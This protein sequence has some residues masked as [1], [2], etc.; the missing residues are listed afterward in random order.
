MIDPGVGTERKA[1]QAL[2]KN[3][4]VDLERYQRLA[5]Q[6]SIAGQQVDTQAALVRQYEATLQTDQAQI[7]AAQLKLT[8]S[9]VTA[10]VDGRV[11]LRQVDLGNY[12]QVGGTTGIVVITQMRPM[13]VVFALPQDEVSTVLE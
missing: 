3:A 11:G 1:D 8:Y 7:D 5:R 2:L 12:V 9:R 13:S 4:Q 10:P 6:D